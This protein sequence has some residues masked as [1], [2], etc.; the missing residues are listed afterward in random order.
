MKQDDNDNIRPVKPNRM[1][2]GKRI[3]GMV[4]LIMALSRA[5]FYDGGSVYE[6]RGLLVL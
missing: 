6:K 3:D 4:A 5:V 1:T 2:S